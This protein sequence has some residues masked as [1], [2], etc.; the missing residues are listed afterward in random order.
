MD[1][2]KYFPLRTTKQV[3]GAYDFLI[4]EEYREEVDCIKSVGYNTYTR[5]LMVVGLIYDKNL[6]SKFLS[7]IWRQGDFDYHKDSMNTW[8]RRYRKRPELHICL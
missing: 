8:H 4:G 3:T 6:L 1:Y 5:R 7:V 2:T